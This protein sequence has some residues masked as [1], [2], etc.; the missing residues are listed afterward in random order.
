MAR[1]LLLFAALAA[2]G[3][4]T[5][6]PRTTPMLGF[7]TWNHYG[8]AGISGKVL[9]DTA[10]S[11]LALG[12]DSLG[13]TFINSDDC[14]MQKERAESGRGPMQ[15]D[16][17][18]FKHGIEP[19]ANYIHSKGLSMGLYTTRANRSCGGYAG[20]CGHE[21]VDMQQWADWQIDYVKDDS[22]GSCNRPVE[23]DYTIMQ[24]AINQ[25][26]RH[27]CLTIEGGANITQASQ[28]TMG[29]ARRVGHDI[30][31]NWI[32]MI[33]LVD[34]AANLWPYVHNGSL[35]VADP[36]QGF[37]NDLDMLELGNGEFQAEHS[38][39]HAAQARTHYTMWCLLKAVMLLGTDLT[40]IGPQTLSIIKTR[41]AV[42]INQ[43]THGN[44]AQR[45]SVQQPR[46]VSLS[47]PSHALVLLALCAGHTPAQRWHYR[48]PNGGIT[49]L[50]YT[51]DSKGQAWCMT[52]PGGG[53]SRWVAVPCDPAAQNYTPRP[54]AAEAW[55]FAPADNG[56]LRVL[57]GW[58]GGKSTLQMGYPA[59]PRGMRGVAPGY[60]ASGPV[61]HTRWVAATVNR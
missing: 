51:I 27:M 30:S 3:G 11:F 44:Q 47:A 23:Q 32:S 36:A 57:G 48:L 45:I 6:A 34:Q 50:L 61:P 41:E 39:L 22:C 24:A 56:T 42:A 49:S 25:S 55:A 53:Q 37:W 40:K 5:T 19:V 12:L 54:G 58:V 2:T 60:G 13:Y 4:S 26:G 59:S 16:P 29:Q 21:Q 38:P 28:G 52:I 9:M 17:F 15:P 1:S 43:D 46:N 14:W 10:D 7:N 20:S 35:S 18:K 8:C 33:S 31:A